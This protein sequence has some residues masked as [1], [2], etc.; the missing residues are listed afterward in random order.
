MR[1]APVASEEKRPK[2]TRRRPRIGTG[3]GPDDSPQDVTG[4]SREMIGKP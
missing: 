2:A 3:M 4:I 1:P